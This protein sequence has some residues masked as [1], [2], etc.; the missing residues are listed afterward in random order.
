MILLTLT[1]RGPKARQAFSGW[2]LTT[3]FTYMGATYVKV[4][5][6]MSTRPDLFPNAFI[7]ELE[8]L[9]DDVGA[10]AFKHVEKTITQDFGAS[11]D[12]LFTSFDKTPVASA[13]VAQV[14]KATLHDGSVV[15]V[16]VRRPHVETIVAFDLFFMKAFAYLLHG[17]PM[18]WIFNLHKSANEF[19]LAIVKQLDLSLEARNN[20]RFRKHFSGDTGVIF[21]KLID[22]LCSSRVLTMSYI[23][24]K[25]VL[26]YQDVQAD[27]K[28]LAQKGLE[29][30]L[31]MVFVDGF[32]HADLHPGNIWVTPSH[33]L[34]ILDL[35]L[36]AELT[37]T[38]KGIFT[39]Y[40][41]AWSA[42]DGPKM[43]AMMA[44][45]SPE[46][47]IKDYSR[48]ETDVVEFVKRYGTAKI[49]EAGVANI[50]LDMMAILRRHK[51][52]SNATFTMVN[53]AL[54][55]VSYTHLTLPT[56]PYV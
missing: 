3:L 1:F 51:V 2:V 24:G 21:P 8:K 39:E 18:L 36:T 23:D 32:V 7:K 41:T 45:F 22:E 52:R 49:G 16:K 50:F 15:A 11:L 5:Q 34:A 48:Y 46:S 37:T 53:L 6:I 25:R 4:G 40:F 54:G 47:R 12:D 42:K 56:T 13:S 19:A 55:T 28:L 20:R 35:G 29:I 17:L 31:Q 38:S 30:V 14:H 10:F 33:K 26:D 44:K 43:A 9:Q 27:P